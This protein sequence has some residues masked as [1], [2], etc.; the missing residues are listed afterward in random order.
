M[1]QC[2]SDLSGEI[3][4]GFLEEMVFGLSSEG[5]LGKRQRDEHS[6][7]GE[8]HVQGLGSGRKPGGRVGV[9][10]CLLPPQAKHLFQPPEASTVPVQFLVTKVGTPG[11]E[12][13]RTLLSFVFCL[14]RLWFC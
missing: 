9:R 8:Q 3:K 12:V 13:F 6:R 7:Q 4:E 5:R 11:S 2:D 10:R 14:L 1:G